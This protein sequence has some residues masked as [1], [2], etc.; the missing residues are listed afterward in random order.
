MPVR[1]ATRSAST[2]S[3]SRR[4]PGEVP[5]AWMSNLPASIEAAFTR[6]SAG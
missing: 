2:A 6:T 4:A 5:A 1:A 3:M